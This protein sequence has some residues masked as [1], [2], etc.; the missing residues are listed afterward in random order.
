[1]STP[2]DTW[3]APRRFSR[4]RRFFQEVPLLGW[5]AGGLAAVL[6]E[7]FVG[8]GLAHLVDLP[9]IPVLFG[10]SPVSNE[11]RLGPHNGN[12]Q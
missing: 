7:Q 12:A 5:L 11:L 8:L 9:R 10:Y 1:M 6:A 3:S 4:L 2:K